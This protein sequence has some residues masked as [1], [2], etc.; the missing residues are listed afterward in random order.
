[1]VRFIDGGSWRKPP[2]C[3]K[4]LTKFI[5]KCCTPHPDRDSNS[6]HFLVLEFF[7]DPY[8]CATVIQ[9]PIQIQIQIFLFPIKEPFRAEQLKKNLIQ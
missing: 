3:R 1:M 8:N 7:K 4:S 2:T 5:T 9:I 6:Q